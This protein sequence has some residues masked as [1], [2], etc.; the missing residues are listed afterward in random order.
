MK[1]WKWVIVAGLL[2]VGGVYLE[3]PIWYPLGVCFLLILIVER[4]H[5]NTPKV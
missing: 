3:L 1:P 5:I 4:K 2:G